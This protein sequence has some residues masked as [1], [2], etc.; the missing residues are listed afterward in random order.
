MVNV[1]MKKF[2]I[3]FLG[4]LQLFLLSLVLVVSPVCSGAVDSSTLSAEKLKKRAALLKRLKKLNLKELSTIQFFNP[5]ATS[6]ARTS[7]KL[8]E[9]AAALFVISSEDIRRAGITHVAEALR[10]APGIQVARINANRWAISARGLNGFSSSKL[11]VMI[12]GRTIYSTLNAMVYWD[13]QDTLIEDIERIEVIRGPGASLWGANAVN[14]IINIITKKTD[15]TQGNLLTTRLGTGEEQVIVGI[16]HGGKI[17][18]KGH[19]RIYGKFYEHDSFVDAQ[20][21]DMDDNQQM[22]RGGFRVD[23]AA[24]KRDDFTV[25]GDVYDGFDK[26]PWL[27]AKEGTSLVDGHSYMTGF[28]LLGR[29]QRNLTNGDMILQSYYDW[30]ERDYHTFYDEVRGT[31]DLD[32]QHR[33]QPDPT[34]EYIWGLAYRYVHDKFDNVPIFGFYPTQREDSLYSAFVQAEFT[35]LSRTSAN[36]AKQSKNDLLRLTLGS[37]FEHNDYTGFEYQP[38]VRLLWTPYEKHSG[39]VAIS[40]AVRVPSRWDADSESKGWINPA[41]RFKA[42]GNHEFQSEEMISYELGYRFSLSKRFLLDTNLFYNDYDKLRTYEPTGLV[43]SPLPPTLLAT[44]DNQKFGEVYGLEFS[45]QWQ[46]TKHWRWIATYSYVDVHL[47]LLQGSQAFAGE[48]EEGDSPHHQATLRSLLTLPNN[49]EFDTAFYYADNVPN[50]NTSAYTRFDV[51]LGW[52]PWPD[53]TLSLGARN[54]FDNQHPEFGIPMA[55]VNI[56][57]DE[58]QRAFY[59]QVNYRF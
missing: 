36:K 28:N 20:G 34:Q 3:Y 27:F 59:M 29:W 41:L 51:R 1:M 12:D 21:Q 38:T 58:V 52:Q 25:Q 15:Q 13:V 19:Y 6:A 11:L 56:V 4:W 39:W 7:R 47:H 26:Q 37:K 57:P 16:R 2:K 24:N 32:F 8:L 33:W 55:S 35:L 14:G 44:L 30:T 22:K 49:W 10:L 9:T 54:L 17:A 48:S 46:A 40:R 45:A 43:M 53:L 42:I 18:N 31:Y 50:Q 23:W 5:E